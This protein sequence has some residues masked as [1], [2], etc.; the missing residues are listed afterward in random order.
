[1]A[2]RYTDEQ[3]AAVDAQIA[4][5]AERNRREKGRVENAEVLLGRAEARVKELE[6][7]LLGLREACTV[8]Y[9]AGMVP[10]EPFVS[11]GNV[12]AKTR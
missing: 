10:A 8:A 11:A 2:N 6:A 1:M 4:A 12:L 9:K 3:I 5:T 7:A